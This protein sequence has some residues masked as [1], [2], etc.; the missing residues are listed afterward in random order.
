VTGTIGL[1]DLGE[2]DV[3]A[4]LRQADDERMLVALNFS[5]RD[6]RLDASVTAPGGTIL[7]STA[8]DRAGAV[9]LAELALRPYEGVLVTLD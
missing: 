5:G 8:M 3:V 1:L 4:Y 2:R 7:C 9:E 6:L